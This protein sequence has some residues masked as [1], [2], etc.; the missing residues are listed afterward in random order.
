MTDCKTIWTGKDGETYCFGSESSKKSFLEN[1]DENLKR[2][3]DFIAASTLESTEKA[4]EDFTGSDAEALVKAS[5]KP[6][7]ARSFGRAYLEGVG[8]RGGSRP[9]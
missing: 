3:R 5:P 4:M 1:P 8:F 9:R 7:R 2:A 6:K